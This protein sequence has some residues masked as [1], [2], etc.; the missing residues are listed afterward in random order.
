MAPDP[1]SARGTLSAYHA[2]CRSAAVG[3]EPKP[4]SVDASDPPVADARVPAAPPAGW[5]P[6]GLPPAP[7]PD[8]PRPVLSWLWLLPQPK[9]THKPS[10]GRV[11]SVTG[12]RTRAVERRHGP[13]HLRRLYTLERLRRQDGTDRDRGRLAEASPVV[14]AGMRSLDIEIGLP[15]E[16]DDR[17]VGRL[18]DVLRDGRGESVGVPD[19]G[20]RVVVGRVRV[21][22]GGAARDQQ[23]ARRHEP[24]PHGPRVTGV[25]HRHQLP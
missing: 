7:P 2:P 8:P 6:A 24:L 5:P 17:Q 3:G 14:Q 11:F 20:R 13:R 15:V 21:F 10:R 16:V 4:L 1:P 12:S 25:E 23:G 22:A 19:A 18:R 9:S